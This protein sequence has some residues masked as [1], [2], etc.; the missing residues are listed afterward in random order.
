[1]DTTPGLGFGVKD[2]LYE[3]ALCQATPTSVIFIGFVQ[4]VWPKFDFR[5]MPKWKRVW[6]W[7]SSSDEE[8]PDRHQVKKSHHARWSKDAMET[9]PY[10]CTTLLPIRSDHPSDK[11]LSTE[12][13]AFN[14]EL[15]CAPIFM[16]N[17][18][19]LNYLPVACHPLLF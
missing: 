7:V 16:M 14:S 11:T 13:N 18:D 8:C 10:P 1:M 15:F 6:A 2:F 5:I 17:D 3:P 19:P 4:Q 12:S 9:L